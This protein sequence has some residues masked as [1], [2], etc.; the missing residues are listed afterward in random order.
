[1]RTRARLTFPARFALLAAMNP[2]PCGHLGDPRYSCRCPPPIVERYRSRISG[3]LLDRIDLHV[4]VPSVTLRELR[5]Q[6][7]E[8]SSAVA[9]RVHR[10]RRLQTERFGENHAEPINAAMGPEELR[11][12]CQLEDGTRLFAT[13]EREGLRLIRHRFPDHHDFVASDIA[14][15]DALPVLMTEKDAVKCRRFAGARH[16]C[17]PVQ[18][19]L[20]EAFAERLLGAIGV[21][22]EAPA[23]P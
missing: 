5:G 23:K 21:P 7:S 10:A 12:H 17:V 13:L 14:F 1:V 19:L 6:P 16:W 2:C 9:E 20:T 3:P 11:V 15:D 22:W 4:E 18:A 8:P